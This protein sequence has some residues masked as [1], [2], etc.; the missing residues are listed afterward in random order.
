[1]QPGGT[2]TGT[3]TD[4]AGTKL[5]GICVLITSAQDAGE[6][7]QSHI[8]VLLGGVPLISAFGV[9]GAKGGYRIANLTPGS[10]EVSFSSG[11]GRP[12][13]TV[14]AAQWFA[15]QGGNQPAW[16]AVRPGLVTSGIGTRLRRGAT[17]TGTIRNASG[18]PV[19]GI[20]PV[21]FASSGQ[22]PAELLALIGSSRSGRNGGEKVT[23]PGAGQ[24]AAA[25]PPRTRGQLAL[26][27]FSEFGRSATH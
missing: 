11:C 12:G 27:L 19:A 18:K 23:R 25:P 3:L 22:P 7:G 5:G 2:I 16:L 9:T 6:L 10:Y 8:G 13:T 15:P 4:R 1:M 24:D 21:A 26:P 14:Y 17:I 20:C